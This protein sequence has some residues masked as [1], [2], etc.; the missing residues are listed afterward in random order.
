MDR[1]LFFKEFYSFQLYQSFFFFMKVRNTVSFLS[2]FS[3]LSNKT[4]EKSLKQDSNQKAIDL[5][6]RL[7]AYLS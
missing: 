4:D 5:K 7:L 2:F 1:K 6:K 3:L